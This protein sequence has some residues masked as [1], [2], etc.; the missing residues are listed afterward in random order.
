MQV[1][2]SYCVDSVT[3]LV[4]DSSRDSLITSICSYLVICFMQLSLPFNKLY[5]NGLVT[6]LFSPEDITHFS[7]IVIKS[8]EPLLDVF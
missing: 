3:E 8:D 6:I 4:N 2:D 5:T 1:R 7:G